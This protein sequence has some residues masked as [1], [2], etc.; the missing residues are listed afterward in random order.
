MSDP[1]LTE[2]ANLRR[3]VADL[4]AERDDLA[5]DNRL[6][7]LES[8]RLLARALAAEAQLEQKRGLR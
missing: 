8:G 7:V 2:L 3:H 6:L 5:L 4:T 1:L